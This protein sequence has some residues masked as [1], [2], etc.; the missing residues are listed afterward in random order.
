MVQDLASLKLLMK[1]VDD[2]EFQLCDIIQE[3]AF[4]N[5]DERWITYRY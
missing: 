1:E 3:L 2:G 4:Y 5:L